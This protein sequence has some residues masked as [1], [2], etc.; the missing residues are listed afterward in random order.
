MSVPKEFFM[1]AEKNRVI[2][3]RVGVILI[4]G[5]K[6]LLI[7]HFKNGRS[8][9]L[10]PGGGLEYGETIAECAS[11][12]LKEETNL[13]VM[14]TKFLFSSES[15][16]PD[17]SR[18]ILNLF[19]LGRISGDS[20]MRLGDE[21]RLKSLALFDIDELD[22]I[23]FYPPIGHLVKSV[24]RTGIADFECERHFGNFW[25]ASPDLR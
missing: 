9:W 19:F 7:E 24:L 10:I 23:E 8:Y 15:I 14:V 21:E 5:D 6:I 3:I 20:P 25:K 22:R 12:E 1:D 11:R 16:A 17:G 13:D 18:H 4:S 2:R